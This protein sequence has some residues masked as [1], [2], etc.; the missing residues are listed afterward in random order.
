MLAAWFSNLATCFIVF[1]ALLLV[2][3]I[4]A[5]GAAAWSWPVEGAVLRPFV[6]GDDPYAGGQ[7]RGI[8]IG[9]PT[10][11]EVRAPA[12]GVVSFAGQVPRQGLCLTIRTEDGYSVTLVHLGSVGLPVGTAVGESDV[13]GTIGPSGDPEWPEPYV[14]LGIRLTADPNGYLDPLSLLPVRQALRR[15]LRNASRSPTRLPRRQTPAP[16]VSTPVLVT[17]R[18]A[19]APRSPA[20]AR[21]ATRA[22]SRRRVSPPVRSRGAPAPHGASAGGRASGTPPGSVAAA[23]AG[24]RPVVATTRTC[25]SPRPRHALARAR[26]A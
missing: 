13:V 19:R 21:R 14:H 6:A 5:P 11:A 26:S 8:D 15:L 12:A 1:F 16:P 20:R 22:R 10:G 3:L 18:R 24:G 17:P 9:A 23:G 4:R 2:A 25:E 7:H